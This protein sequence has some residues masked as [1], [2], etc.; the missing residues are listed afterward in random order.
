M[1]SLQMSNAVYYL[2]GRGGRL[3]KGLGMELQRRGLVVNGREMHGEFA[4]LAFSEQAAIVA[5]DLSSNH[6][7]ENSKVI[8]N[9]FGAYL[10]LYALSKLPPFTGKVI[11]FSPIVGEFS[12]EATMMNFVPPRS[13]ELK[14][15]IFSGEFPAPHHCEMHVGEFD[16]QSNP[17]NVEIVCKF[18]QASYFL[19]EDAGHMLPKDYVSTVLDRWFS[20]VQPSTT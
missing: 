11:C 15:Q 10:F 9:S 4:K 12:N 18:L 3:N 2:P 5:N 7:T 6:W 1:M 14:E 19:V 16:W 8:C 17:N 13:D 20:K